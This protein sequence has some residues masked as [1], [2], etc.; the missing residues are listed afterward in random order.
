MFKNLKQKIT[1]GDNIYFFR[2]LKFAK[3]HLIPFAIGQFFYSAQEFIF[4]FAMSVLMGNIMAAM[5]AGSREMVMTTIWNFILMLLGFI[6]FLGLGIALYIY[7]SERI[8]QDVRQLLFRTFMRSGAEEATASHSGDG[9]A[10]INTDANT[11]SQMFGQPLTN[12]LSNIIVIFG[13]TGTIFVVDWSLGLAAVGVGILSFIF[14]IRFTKPIA[15]IGKEQLAAN[16]ETVKSASNIFNG[17]MAIRAYN[18]QR[19][20]LVT[21]DRD[22]KKIKLLDF[23][24]ALI[25]T[26]REIFS[27]VEIWLSLVVTF[28][29]GGW[30]VANGHLEFHL[31]MIVAGMF[32]TFVRAIGSIGSTYAQLQIPLAGAKRVFEVLDSGDVLV[33]D[34][35]E[36]SI[37]ERNGYGLTLDNL[38]F[39]YNGQEKNALK[40]LNLAIAENEM[41]A[42]VGESGSGK[43]TLLRAMVGLYDRNDLGMTVGGVVFNDS[44]VKSWRESFAY[45]DQSCK[46]FDMTISENIAMGKGGQAEIAE[47]EFAAKRAVAHDFILE[48]TDGYETACG[49]KGASLSGGQ[50][51]RIAIARALV[52]KAPILVFD[53]ATSALD[54]ESERSIMETIENLRAD[55][56]VLIVTHNLHNIKTADKIVV[57]KDGA[58]V[59]VGNHDELLA[60]NGEYVELLTKE[61]Q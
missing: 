28:V 17:S 23:R 36:I 14:Q 48:Q 18:T 29:F 38:N 54:T 5:V 6:V 21:F 15:E 58:I 45:V 44:D 27:L 10:S 31:L 22:N 34:Q 61:K 19:R 13:A 47:I 20:A 59:E 51:Q 46:L 49:E 39:A 52:R 9:I 50:K 7:F 32:T 4:S 16:A 42:F 33:K 24:S 1:A 26:W 41:V 56:T 43:S 40:G 2:G 8:M 55:H 57:M 25:D 53:E 35:K 60:Q 37:A 3:P 11:M 12:V 30:L